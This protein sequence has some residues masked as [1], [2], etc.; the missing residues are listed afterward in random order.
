[1]LEATQVSLSLQSVL[2]ALVIPLL[3]E[4]LH[5]SSGHL[6]P[7]RKLHHRFVLHLEV[8]LELLP[9]LYLDHLIES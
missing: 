6:E 3:L 8:L 5:L 1:M 7:L 2:A 4:S 9:E